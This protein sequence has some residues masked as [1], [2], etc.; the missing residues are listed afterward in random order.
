MKSACMTRPLLAHE[1]SLHSP[2]HLGR[3]GAGQWGCILHHG[4]PPLPIVDL[5]IHLM[6][7]VNSG[8]EEQ[9]LGLTAGIPIPALPL[10]ACVA[11]ADSLVFFLVSSSVKWGPQWCRTSSGYCEAN[12]A[13]PLEE[14][15][16]TVTCNCQPLTTTCACSLPGPGNRLASLHRG[17]PVPSPPPS[18]ESPSCLSGLDAWI[19]QQN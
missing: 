4:T 1:A 5:L 12:I 6:K 7:L 14:C 13:Q 18:G 9:G 3:R 17:R 10:P 19:S 16:T 8:A 11:V 15:L 2:C